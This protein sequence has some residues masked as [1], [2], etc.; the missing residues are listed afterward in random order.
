MRDFSSPLTHTPRVCTQRPKRKVDPHSRPFV[1]GGTCL[2]GTVSLIYTQQT[3]T[4]LRSRSISPIWQTPVTPKS[5]GNF[6]RC[7]YAR[8]SLRHCEN[9]ASR[10][11]RAL[12]SRTTM[13]IRSRGDACAVVREK[14]T[15][16]PPPR[17]H[18]HSTSVLRR[19]KSASGPLVFLPGYPSGVPPLS[20]SLV[21]C[22][23]PRAPITRRNAHLVR[24]GGPIMVSDHSKLLSTHGF[25]SE[26]HGRLPPAPE[27]LIRLR[28]PPTT[29]LSESTF[30]QRRLRLAPRRCRRLAF[31]ITVMVHAAGV[32]TPIVR[33]RLRDANL[34]EKPFYRSPR[35]SSPSSPSL[36]LSLPS[37]QSR[38]SDSPILHIRCLDS[39]ALGPPVLHD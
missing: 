11:R 31:L 1:V 33:W 32:E 35:S 28:R 17:P 22:I 36:S 30:G 21:H 15:L 23:S 26:A 5:T 24:G 25:S 16:P 27:F 3:G 12:T 19:T 37:S 2:Y 10:E 39:G 38:C 4:L 14:L 7:T 8:R 13:V 9:S 6:R 34:R 18:P 20:H 29:N